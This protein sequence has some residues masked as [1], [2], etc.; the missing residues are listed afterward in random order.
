RH[1]LRERLRYR[2][3]GLPMAQERHSHHWRDFDQLHHPGH[4]ILGYRFAVHCHGQQHGGQRN[5]QCSHADGQCRCGGAFDYHSA[6]QP[7][8]DGWADGHVQRGSDGYRTLELPVDERRHHHS[9]G[10]VF[11]LHHPG[12]YI[13]GYRFAVHCGGQQHSGQCDEQRR[14]PHGECGSR[15]RHS[16]ESYFPQLWKRRDWEHVV[17]SL[18]HHQYRDGHTGHYPSDR[19][20]LG[21]LHCQWIFAALECEPRST[22]LNYGGFLANRSWHRISQ[23]LHCEQHAWLSV[24]HFPKR[25]RHGHNLSAGVQA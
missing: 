13:L 10:D 23:H 25:H 19:S 21:V 9:G 6:G 24:G 15:T 22:D 1:F 20:W 16:G 7:D 18:D 2:T 8:G 3:D 14:R 12:H 11:E 4:Y 17:T 5:Q